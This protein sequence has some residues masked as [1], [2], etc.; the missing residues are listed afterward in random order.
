M[1]TSKV[2]GF[3]GNA[4][5]KILFPEEADNI[6]KILELPGVNAI[7]QPLLD[8]LEVKMNQAAEKAAPLAKDIFINAITNLTITDAL[9]IFRWR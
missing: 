8:G 9:S 1:E 3:F 2:N 5:I 7:G 6:K 4:A